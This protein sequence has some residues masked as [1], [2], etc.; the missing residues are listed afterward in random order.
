M[1]S[2][3]ISIAEVLRRECERILLSIRPPEYRS[4]LKTVL[5]EQ[6]PPEMVKNWPAVLFCL[7]ESEANPSRYAKGMIDRTYTFRLSLYT[8]EHF[9]QSSRMLLDAL[10]EDVEKAFVEEQGPSQLTVTRETGAS[11]TQWS[12]PRWVKFETS[13][14][15]PFGIG[16]GI[17][18]ASVRYQRG[19]P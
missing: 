2:S 3:E 7:D 16:L 12:A 1:A 6:V 10:S 13:L 4:D 18:E 14:Y 8:H 5:Q 11:L 9:K 17:V 15:R 19:R